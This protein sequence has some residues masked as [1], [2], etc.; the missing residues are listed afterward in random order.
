[1]HKR[2]PQLH[3]GLPISCVFTLS[4]PPFAPYLAWEPISSNGNEV[5]V[6]VDLDLF[7]LAPGR[8]YMYGMYDVCGED[9]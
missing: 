4:F 9:V 7:L 1:M 6:Y 8:L 5:G 3:R 2:R